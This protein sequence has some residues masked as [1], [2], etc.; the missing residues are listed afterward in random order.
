M[1]GVRTGLVAALVFLGAAGAQ[2]QVENPW[3][4]RGRAIVVAPNA[5]SDNLNLDAATN[6]TMEVDI[7]RYLT[8]HLSLELILA[9]TGHEVKSGPGSLGSANALPPTLLL[10]FRPSSQGV[11]PYLGAGGNLTYFYGKSG[12]G[13]LDKLDL[14]TSFGWAV[15]AGVDVPLGPWVF[16]LDAKYIRIGTDVKSGGTKVAHLKLNPFVIGTGF[17][18]RI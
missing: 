6:A 2:A 5:S 13:G 9:T 8:N 15:Q 18:I 17:G 10:Q 4:I 1:R 14:T 7:S 12:T 11:S 3:L 16:N